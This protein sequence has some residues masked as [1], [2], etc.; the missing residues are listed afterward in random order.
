MDRGDAAIKAES[1]TE[2]IEQTLLGKEINEIK[3]SDLARLVMELLLEHEPQVFLA[4]LTYFNT[5]SRA[6]KSHHF[7]KKYWKKVIQKAVG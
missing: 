5:M 1:L 3:S 7:S 2:M 6:K 4:Y